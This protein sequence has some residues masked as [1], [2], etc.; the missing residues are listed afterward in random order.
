MRKER[1][2]LHIKCELCPHRDVCLARGLDEPELEIINNLIIDVLNLKKGDII[3]QQ[4]QKMNNLFAV[5][6]GCCQEHWVDKNGHEYVENFFLPGDILGFEHIP[7]KKYLYSA[8]ALATSQVCVIPVEA[9]FDAAQ[10]SEKIFRRLIN[11]ASYK[12]LNNSYLKQGTNAKSRVANFLLSM[13]MRYEERQV[14]SDKIALPMTRIAISNLL[15]IAYETVS[16]IL[17]DLSRQEIIRI[18]NKGICILNMDKLKEIA[19]PIEHFGQVD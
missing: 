9:L 16:R 7:L 14:H 11:L 3:Y 2:K 8:S 10:N 18:Y 17:H 19:N 6:K 1:K 13:L 4:G 12:M 5:H 15:G